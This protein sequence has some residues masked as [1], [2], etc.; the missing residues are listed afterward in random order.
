MEKIEFI[1]ADNGR[2]LK[3]LSKKLEDVKYSAIDKS[4]RQKDIKV[5]DKRI[6]DNVNIVCG[7]KI[8]IFIDD[9]AH[10]KLYEIIYEDE[11]IIVINKSKG[12]EVC[13]GEFNLESELK[14]NGISVYSVHRLDRNTSGLT[15]FAKKE[16]VRDNLIEQF[17]KHNIEKFYLAKVFG[18]LDD[19]EKTLV[20][21][22][23]KDEKNSRV[24][25]SNDKKVGLVKIETH[26]KVLDE[27]EKY[28][29]LEVKISQGKTHQI[30]AHLASCGHAIVGDGKY[31]NNQNNQSA[32]EKTQMLVAYKICFH[33]DENSELNYLNNTSIKLNEKEILTQFKK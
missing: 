28:S 14:K 2:V 32:K 20:G 4:L 25:I 5:N 12:I 22:L 18:H 9:S 26:Y 7:D 15:I 31:G 8:T 13:N 29:I 17:K 6:S 23:Q 24:F 30:R 21:Y 16:R 27:I 19:K 3:V 1:S 10:K 11:N 33:I